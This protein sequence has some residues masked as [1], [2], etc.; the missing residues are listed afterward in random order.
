MALDK[1]TTNIIN[2]D[3]V[4]G[5]KI[6]NNPTVAGNLTVAGNTTLSGTS[7]LTGNATA[8]GNLT[9]TG[10]IIPSTPF[11]HRNLIINGAF[12]VWQRSNSTSLET[13]ANNNLKAD[14][15]KLN[16]D[17]QA[18]DLTCA[19]STDVPA[20]Q[21]FTNSMKVV[22]GGADTSVAS[23]HI[24]TIVQYIE[25]QDL[26][27]LCYGTSNAKTLT[28]SFWV[29]TN[30]TGLHS[31]CLVKPDSTNYACPIEY[32][33][34]AANTWEKKEIT[35]SPTAGSTSLITSSAGAIADDTGRGMSVCWNLAAGS[36]YRGTN[37]T[38][39]A[40]P[41]SEYG[42]GTGTIQ[43]FVGST[44]NTFFLTGCQLEL[45]SN[46]TPFE[47]RSYG[48]EFIRCE[49]YYSTSFE[50]HIKPVGT[51]ASAFNNKHLYFHI[52]PYTGAHFA[53]IQ[54]V[55][56]TKMRTSPS[57]TFWTG[58]GSPSADS[59]RVAY[60]EGSWASNNGF[61]VDTTGSGPFGFNLGG[62][63]SSSTRLCQFNFTA[64]A[65]L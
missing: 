5:A 18:A 54:V 9:V 40:G 34:S 59:G 3:A 38:W 22:P 23:S 50:D 8:S 63:I 52:Y 53:G 65:E 32:T 27:H 15:F 25:A 44:S 57:V 45:G 39:Q 43:N 42:H 24:A 56:K 62:T 1:V 16:S 35:F 11:S 12:Q 6:E 7:T 58:R 2:D 41:A 46:A 33:V 49:R 19:R 47:H 55:Y 60:W 4:T 26:Q 51:H 14:R 21:G 31:V 48:E 36:T 17:I 29:K 13:V 30:L 64:D 10:D 20:G 61:S 37:N 28:L